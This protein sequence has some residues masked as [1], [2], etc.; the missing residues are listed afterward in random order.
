MRTTLIIIP[1][2]FCASPALAQVG[3]PPLLP[4]ELTDP[5]TA[6]RLAGTMQAVS[7]ALLD[8]RVGRMRAALEGREASPQERNLTVRDLARRK[9]PDFDRHFQQQVGSVGPKI[10][11]TMRAV[12]EELPAVMQDLAQAQRSL[13]R[14]VANMPDPTYPRR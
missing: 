11:R 14:A 2:L 7:N 5:A 13:E 1:L 8:V 10:Q 4:P 9:D 3:P 12:N 6:Q